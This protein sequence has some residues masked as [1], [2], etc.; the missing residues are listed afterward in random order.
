MQIEHL[1]P[2]SGVVVKDKGERDDK[3]IDDKGGRMVDTEYA[4]EERGLGLFCPPVSIH[5]E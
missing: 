1:V 4:K 3:E 2:S 5:G